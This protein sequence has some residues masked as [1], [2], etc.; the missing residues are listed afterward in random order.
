[1]R[2]G[3]E[4]SDG[5]D[6]DYYRTFENRLPPEHKWIA[7]VLDSQIANYTGLCLSEGVSSSQD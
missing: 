4:A 3:K 6:V 1:M 5:G 7:L 2:R